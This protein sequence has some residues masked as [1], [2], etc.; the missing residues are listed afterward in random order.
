MKAY[1][2]KIILKNSKPPVWRR[3]LI[4]A[5]ITFSQLAL[6]LE[7][8]VES[9]KCARYVFEFYQAGIHVHE[10]WEGER[11]VTAFSYSYLCASDTYINSLADKEAWFTFRPGDKCQ[12]RVEIE[13]RL[14]EGIPF[15][16]IIR[17]KGDS[18]ECLW[19]DIEAVNRILEQRYPLHYGKPDY[20]VFEELWKDVEKNKRGISG[21]SHPKDRT[22]RNEGCADSMMKGTADVLLQRYS[23][24]MTEKIMEELKRGENDGSIDSD[25]LRDILEDTAWRMKQ[26]VR[27]S[28]FGRDVSEMI[29]RHPDIKE[30]LLGETKETLREMAEDLQISPYKSL[31]KNGLADKIR[32]EILKPE[33]MA[34]RMLL[35]SDAEIS[36]FE[37]AAARESGYYPNPA[38]MKNLERLYD[39]LYVLL[40]HDDYAEVPREVAER[41]RMIN[42][43]AYQEKRRG[44]Y[45]LYHCLMIVELFY[46]CAPVKIICRM[47]KDCL[48]HRVER[49][50]LETLWGNIP[51][52]L[53][54]CVLQGD[55]IIY[56]EVLKNS[57]YLHIEKVQEGK[58]FYI[59]GP[60]EIVEYTENGYPVSDPCYRR[61]KTF[62][63]REM[64]MDMDKAEEYMAVIWGQVSMGNSLLDIMDIFEE[65]FIFPTKDALETFVFIM[66]EVNNHT[67]MVANRGWTPEEILTRMPPVPQGKRTTIV[68]M[69]SEAAALL[70]ESSKELKSM[71]FEVDLDHN[72]DEITTTFMPDGPSGKIITGKKKIYPNDPCPCGSGKKYKKCCGRK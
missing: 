67:R 27:A 14:A 3:C 35:L 16:V 1:Q 56:K 66:T 51:D 20:R 37:K 31:N 50:E 40:Y 44:T 70:G 63:V 69:S 71:G 65:D 38:E 21:A 12:Y 57:L 72:A 59:P 30:F 25:V 24:E 64:N 34:K 18:P 45:W 55:R 53:N 68:P 19:S 6:I 8:V 13:K 39:L 4:P 54:P 49:K 7:D 33:N 48:G 47:M 41:Y 11:Q 17:Q 15:P 58:D 5:G 28:V 46:A 2:V 29:S 62:F 61:L 60:D 23:H 52:E 26:D 9:R 10:W 43:P 32:D 22:D 42:T 36:E